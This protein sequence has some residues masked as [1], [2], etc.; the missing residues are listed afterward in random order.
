[1]DEMLESGQGEKEREQI[2]ENEDGNDGVHGQEAGD[3]DRRDAA[4]LAQK[5]KRKKKNL[6]EQERKLA[7]QGGQGLIE[8]SDVEM[9]KEAVK[10]N[11]HALKIAAIESHLKEKDRRSCVLLKRLKAI[12]WAKR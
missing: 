3:A 7:R 11:G 2:A 5:K 1:M 10:L 8:R 6:G 4:A 9:R 12:S